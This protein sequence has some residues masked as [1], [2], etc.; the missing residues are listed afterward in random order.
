[1]QDMS[2]TKEQL[3]MELVQLRQKLARLEATDHDPDSEADPDSAFDALKESD[4]K[5]RT[6]TENTTAHITIIQDDRYVYANQA[7]LDYYE[8]DA[9]DLQ[10]VTVEDLMVGM[11]APE[12]IAQVM[13]LWQRAMERGDTCFSF[14]IPYLDGSWFQTNVTMMELDGKP[15]YMIM[16]FDITELKRAQSEMFRADLSPSSRRRGGTRALV[17]GFRSRIASSRSTAGRSASK[18]SSAKAPV[19][20]CCCRPPTRTRHPPRVPECFRVYQFEIVGW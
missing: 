9:E 4:K 10:L 5:F 11:I 1:M 16:E 2:K 19:S 17:W 20:R 12:A 8:L 13:P 7:F 15:A 18:A 14:E 6:L 3:I